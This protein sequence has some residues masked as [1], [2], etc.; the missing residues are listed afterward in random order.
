MLAAYRELRNNETDT[1]ELDAHL[2]QCASCRRVLAQYSLIGGQIRSLPTIEPPPTA[3]AKLMHTL[4]TE[5]L[6]YMQRATPGAY[7]APEFLKPYLQE[8]TQKHFQYTQAI[9][10][11]IALST[12][13]TGPL[14]IIRAPSKRHRRLHISQLAAIGLAAAFLMAVMM[15]GITTLLVLTRGGVQQ[16]VIRSSGS[17]S[18]GHLANVVR[19][20]YRTNTSYQHVVSA[21]ADRTDIYYTAYGDASNEGWMLEQMDRRAGVSTPLLTSASASPLIV[22]GSANGWL[23]WLQFDPAKPSTNHKN[24][25]HHNLPVVKRTWSLHYLSLTSLLQPEIFAPAEPLTL[26]SGTFNQGSGPDW[27]YTPVQGIWFIQNSLLVASI[28]ENGISRLSSYQLDA[29]NHTISKAIATASPGHVFTSPTANED[30]TE[31][32][33]SDEWRT[34]DGVLHSNI[35]TQQVSEVPNPLH[36]RWGEHTVTVKQLFRAN[37]A[38]FSPEVVD[39]TLFLLST[40]DATDTAQATPGTTPATIPTGVPTTIP[41]TPITSWADSSIYIAPIDRSVRGWLLM[42]PLDD[43]TATPTEVNAGQAWSLQVGTDFVLWQSDQGYQMF[44]VATTSAVSVGNVLDGARFL[45][46]NGDTTVWTIDVPTNVSDNTNPAVT[47]L[48]FNWPT[49]S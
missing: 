48:A 39:N 4:A 28:D 44:D 14:P 10:P 41:N 13:E 6:H 23:V 7:P 35:W 37:S 21:V 34:D 42:L 29:P 25:S 38:S 45:A 32:Y 36:G 11:L 5:H 12:A 1:T 24:L 16:A 15:S 49:K 3:H 17:T 43:P 40:T 31:I 26:A 47:L 27:I 33:W 30:G 8:H 19:A 20:V 18:V 46:V 2:E 9:D 22:L